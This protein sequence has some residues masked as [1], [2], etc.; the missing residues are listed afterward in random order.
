MR[1][2][3]VTDLHKVLDDPAAG[4]QGDADV[5]E[6]EQAEHPD[7]WCFESGTNQG[8]GFAASRGATAL[9]RA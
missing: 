9:V 4:R 1:Q 6:V 8:H 3:A 7:A 2:V 5:E